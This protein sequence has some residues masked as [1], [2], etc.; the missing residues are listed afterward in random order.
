MVKRGSNTPSA[1]SVMRSSVA[2]SRSVEK[3]F[4]HKAEVSRLRHH[5]SVLSRRLHQS[6]LESESL[7]REL[8]ALRSVAPLSPEG[9]GS[10]A[11][12]SCEEVANVVA[13]HAPVAVPAAPMVARFFEARVAEEVVAVTSVASPFGGQ[14]PEPGVAE[15]GLPVVEVARSLLAGGAVAKRHPRRVRWMDDEAGVVA[16]KA[17]VVEVIVSSSPPPV[18]PG[19]PCV[20]PA[21]AVVGGD[22]SE[23]HALDP[24]FITVGSRRRRK[25][26]GGHH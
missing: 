4:A 9:D 14:E 8:D 17:R 1:A 2:L 26:R 18:P 16:R 23:R 5:V 15:P 24:G 25:G 7:R 12:S 19:R 13:V 11:P 6:A 10:E 22:G 21:A 20:S 3:T